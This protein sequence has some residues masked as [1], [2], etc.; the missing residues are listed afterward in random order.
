MSNIK[1]T[2]LG[3]VQ[4]DAQAVEVTRI[5]NSTSD[6]IERVKR[7]KDYLGMFHDDLVKK[8]VPPDYLAYVIEFAASG[9]P[10]LFNKI[11]EHFTR[12]ATK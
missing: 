5:L 3:D 8:G 7:L 9:N 6:P 11:G 1:T 12:K 10:K 2:K 4:T